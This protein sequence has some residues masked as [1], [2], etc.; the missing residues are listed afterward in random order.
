MGGFLEDVGTAILKGV[1]GKRKTN[2]FLINRLVGRCR[3][4]PHPWSTRGDYVSWPGLKD[5]N[6]FG[7]LLPST[8]WPGAH[9]P[10]LPPREDVT[11]LFIAGPG[12]QRLC[13][14]STC[15]FPAFA[16]YLTDGF[17][18]TRL[19][20]I[21]AEED[22]TRTT[23]NHEIDLSTLYGR[24][25]WQTLALRR[26]SEQMGERGRLKSETIAGEEWPLR[27]FLP[28]GN[29]ID[30]QF[31]DPASGKPLLDTPLGIDNT[32]PEMRAT[33]LAVGGDRVNAAPQTAMM[34]VL[35]LREH[36]RIAGL[37]EQDHPH[38]DDDRVF[39]TVRNVMIVMFIKLVVEEYIN[40]VSTAK[41]KLKAWPEVAWKAGWN[42]ENWMTIE[43]TL[44]YRWHSL[45]P[46]TMRWADVEIGG[47]ALLLDNRV[48]LEGGLASA[49]ADISANPA[50]ELGLGNA[51]EFMR[52]AEMN[53]LKQSQTNK[54]QGYAAYRRAMGKKVPKDFA[55]LV[56]KSK[57]PA[58]QERRTALA[59]AL[60]V[61]YGSVDGLEFYTGLFAEPREKN[62]PLPD[63]LTA[64]VAMDAFSQALT[65]PLLSEHVWGDEDIR[66]ETFTQRGLD[67]MTDTA[68][69]RDILARNTDDLGDRFVGMTR[70]DWQRE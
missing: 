27:L 64:M 1:L 51:A 38:W 20:N 31:L 70:P 25:E 15:L 34:N 12:D 26:R 22:R 2:A 35:F 21:E 52:K 68:C 69:L 67:I 4:R 43:F 63:L 56:G 42:R 23:S 40:H 16:Q 66:R 46:R 7:R 32:S 8:N 5:R 45:V 3:N 65:N 61:L 50:T 49:F 59:A 30:P 37:F 18:R 28:G 47:D 6:Y 14:K 24:G 44:L 55:T 33:L 58:E 39:E 17:L 60:K 10:V 41:I 57:D 11:G 9:Q 36:N 53:A 54:L 29:E 19:S 48:L 13:P 62:G